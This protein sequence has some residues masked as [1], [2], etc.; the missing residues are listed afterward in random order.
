MVEYIEREALREILDGWRDAHADVD[1]VHGCGLLEDVICEVD[2][3]TAADV[4][5]VV[6]GR[7]IHS[8][9]EDCSEQ[10]ELVKCSQCNHEAYAMAFYVCGGNYCPNC[11]A[12]MDIEAGGDNNLDEVSGVVDACPTVDAVPAVRCKDCTHCVRTTDIDGPG[13]FCSIWGRQWNR[14]QLDDFCSYGERKD[15]ED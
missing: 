9:Y 5:P 10:F 1:D 3:Q 6:H 12:K 8:R 4:A 13:L 7:W 15:G 2:A 14:V 11:G